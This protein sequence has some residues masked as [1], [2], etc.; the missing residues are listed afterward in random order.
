VARDAAIWF[1]LV[2]G[3]EA[4]P[5][6]RAELSLEVG[7]QVVTGE[8]LVWREGMGGWE[9]AASLAD[10]APLFA[11]EPQPLPARPPQQPKGRPVAS[12]VQTRSAA[13]TREGGKSAFTPEQADVVKQKFGGGNLELDTASFAAAEVEAAAAI[14]SRK[15]ERAGGLVEFDTASFAAADLEARLEV[16]DGPGGQGKGVA[17]EGPLELDEE[18]RVRA[19]VAGRKAPPQRALASQQPAKLQSSRGAPQQP[20]KIQIAVPAP[21][22][23]GSGTSTNLL[24][25]LLGVIAAVILGLTFLVL[26]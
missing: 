9:P 2:E 24:Y 5:V 23:K 15:E 19:G 13:A 20:V 3:A 8:T 18:A 11:S 21:A 7:A 16:K 26:R 4:G 10:L 25:G 6:S 22:A 12:K 1:Y 17:D 14:A